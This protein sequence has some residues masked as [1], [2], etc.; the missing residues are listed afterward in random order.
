MAI[1]ANFVVVILTINGAFFYRDINFG[2]MPITFFNVF[3]FIA[4]TCMMLAFTTAIK[5][6]KAL[7]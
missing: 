6:M 2:I 1:I 7:E 5:R 4:H 3:L